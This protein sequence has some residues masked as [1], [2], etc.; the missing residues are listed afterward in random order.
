M[1]LLGSLT[2]IVLAIFR[3]N[4][5]QITLQPNSSTTYTADRVVSLPNQD[6]DAE[7]VS[8]NASQTLTNK[9]IDVSSN[10]VSNIVNSNISNSAA[11]AWSKVDKSGSN[12]TD[13]VTKSHTSLSDIGTNTHDQID[14]ALSTAASHE[15]ASS[16]VHG[17]TG[18]VVGTSDSQA[19][20]NKTISAD[21][22]SISNLVV[23]NFKTVIANSYKFFTWDGFGVPLSTKSVPTG[24]V[25]GTID[26]Q[27]LTNKD[28]DGAGATNLSRITIPKSST[29]TLNGLTRK[30]AT[31]VY[32]TSD[33]VLYFDNGSSLVPVNPVKNT[34]TLPDNTVGTIVL[35]VPVATYQ[36]VIINYSLSRAAGQ[37]R[38]GQIFL[39]YDGTSANVVDTSLEASDCGVTFSADIH[40]GSLRLLADT[41]S[42]SNDCSMVYFL[43]QW[44]N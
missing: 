7:L 27:Q 3:Q 41:T 30:E 17:V 24:D 1:K 32:S 18:S 44:A 43:N 19:L 36:N 10:T 8:L 6:A 33:H 40:S 14:S 11:I 5:K 35:S 4:G 39:M 12:L 9:T 37:R 42:T 16:G 23:S 20:T 38:M 26:Y 31:V 2:E 34:F 21:S 22:N 29:S 28:I 25:L 13:I 15:G